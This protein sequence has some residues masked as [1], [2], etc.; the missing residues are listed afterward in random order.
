[1]TPEQHLRHFAEF[2]IGVQLSGGTTP[3]MLM[4]AEMARRQDNAE[5]ALWWAGCY[6][7]VYNFATAEVINMHWRQPGAVLGAGAGEELREWLAKHWKGIK[8]RKER[9]AARSV[10]KLATCMESYAAFVPRVLAAPWFSPH[11]DWPER[12]RYEAAFDAMLADVKYM[13]RYIT[14]RW[15]ET[16]GRVFGLP[17]TMPDLRSKD[18]E[19]PRKALSFMYPEAA[20]VLLGGDDDAT[21]A[22]VDEIVEQCR[23][24]LRRHYGF[25]LDYYTMQSLLC[26][27]KQSFL[28]KK[29][30]PGKSVD[31]ALRYWSGVE[32]YWRE[33]YSR[34]SQ[35]WDVRAT[36]FPAF[37]LGEA[38]GWTSV[39]EELG[40]TLV[41]HGYTWSDGIYDYGATTSG[42]P[43]GH[44]SLGRP[45]FRAGALSW[46]WPRKEGRQ[47]QR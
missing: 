14:I 26:E 1:M 15:I 7:F 39:R 32:E 10:E 6:C 36:L 29:Q 21:V 25:D 30:Y 38:N 17:L 47:W 35:M 28:R 46:A 37:V 5:Q 2:C 13:G 27:Y 12:R 43:G 19:H 42:G 3:H 44:H 45:A 23:G 33:R 8:W 16:I 9:K 24:D 34:D 31:T 20:D 11:C 40:T 18:G 4:A 41:D 22:A